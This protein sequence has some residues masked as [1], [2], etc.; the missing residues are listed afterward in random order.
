MKIHKFFIMI[1]FIWKIYHIL[2]FIKFLFI[3][4]HIRFYFPKLKHL[5]VLL[6]LH[7]LIR[8]IRILKLGN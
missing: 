6:L 7:F 4:N 1:I 8:K 5:K 3:L 2:L